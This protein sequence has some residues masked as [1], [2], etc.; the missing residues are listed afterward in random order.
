MDYRYARHAAE[1]MREAVTY[2]YAT[3]IAAYPPLITFKTWLTS[4][5]GSEPLA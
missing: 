4:M 5:R 1:L 2:G 3:E